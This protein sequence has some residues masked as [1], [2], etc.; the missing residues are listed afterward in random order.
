MDEQNRHDAI[1]DYVTV[2]QLMND[3]LLEPLLRSPKL[4]EHVEALNRVMVIEHQRRRQFYDEITEE[5][6]WE[7]INGQVIMHSPATNRHNRIVARLANLINSWV[8]KNELGQVTFEKTL[9]QFPR[10]DYEPD[11][12]F[13]GIAKSAHIQPK[14]LLHPIPDFVVEVL[15]E[16]TEAIDRG[17]KFTDYE[18]HGVQEYWIVNPDEEFVEQ[19]QL[20]NGAYRKSELRGADRIFSG[21]IAGLEVS[22]RAVF[23]DT[24]NLAELR[25]LLDL[26]KG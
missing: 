15:S 5:R 1:E 8:V 13:F 4:P 19:Y 23:D 2:P 14:T 26:S 21:A 9:C 7:F 25:R 16:S 10:N 22:V 17:I 12:V 11:I 6:K 24:A 20:E 3:S 18:A